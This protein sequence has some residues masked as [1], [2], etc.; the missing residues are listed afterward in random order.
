MRVALSKVLRAHVEMLKCKQ[1]ITP[2][3]YRIRFRV[4]Y[5]YP[6][7]A[8]RLFLKSGRRQSFYVVN[9]RAKEGVVENK[10]A[11]TT[12]SLACNYLVTLL[13]LYPSSSGESVPNSRSWRQQP[14]TY[15]Y[16]TR[17]PPHSGTLILLCLQIHLQVRIRIS[18][19]WSPVRPWNWM[20]SQLV[21]PVASLMHSFPANKMQLRRFLLFTS[22]CFGFVSRSTQK[23]K[24]GWRDYGQR[25]SA[26]S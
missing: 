8:N 13:I 6:T 17:A 7:W 16:C 18:C 5:S 25:S 21:L 14:G 11:L 10:V 22:H 2:E 23:M 4:L 1:I 12:P 19:C 24:V 9:I 26:R 20:D 3:E 15:Y